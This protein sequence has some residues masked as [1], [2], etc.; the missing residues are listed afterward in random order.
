MRAR[1]GADKAANVLQRLEEHRSRERVLNGHHSPG[2]GLPPFNRRGATMSGR[3]AIRV[4]TAGALVVLLASSPA[5]AGRQQKS[6]A[7]KTAALLFVMR[8]ASGSFTA[9]G[10]GQA[11]VYDLK[12][13]GVHPDTVWFTDRPDRQADTVTTDAALRMIDFG[14]KD[15]PP[16]AVVDIRGGDPRHNALAVKLEEPQFDAASGSLRLTATLLPKPNAKSGLA[17][18][19][20]RLD[21]SI[22]ESFG[23][24]SLFIDDADTPVEANGQPIVPTDA[25]VVAKGQQCGSKG[26]IACP[27]PGAQ[28]VGRET[29]APP[30]APRADQWLVDIKVVTS[31]SPGVACPAGYVKDGRDLNE[32]AGGDYIYLC[33]L[34][35]SDRSRSISLP[36]VLITKDPAVRCASNSKLDVDLNKG[37]GGAYIYFC[38]N[39]KGQAPAAG[40]LP[41]QYVKDI[42]FDVYGTS[43]TAFNPPCN[44]WDPRFTTVTDFGPGEGWIRAAVDQNSNYYPVVYGDLNEAAGGKFIYTCVYRVDA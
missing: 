12:V 35:G 17:G 10:A 4:F 5:S 24:V 39:R 31:G 37:A 11:G 44:G 28:Q 8:A 14:A 34:F 22:P 2:V 16:N 41:S 29:P 32:G 9:R 3:W 18:F 1:N 26:G 43:P 6:N 36:S 23:D 33:K 30:Q 40:G 21:R 25:G 42:A 13:A 7:P 20:A 27:K 38:Y 15:T 19:D